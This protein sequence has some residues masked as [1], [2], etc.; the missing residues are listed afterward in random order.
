MAAWVGTAQAL[1]AMK[2]KWRG[3]LM[4]I[5]QP[6]EE[7][8]TGARAMLAD[9]LFERFPKPDVGF[10]LHVG[11]GPAG[12]V[13]YRPG[14]NSSNSDSLDITFHGK[15]GHGSTPHVTIDPVSRPPASPWM[16]RP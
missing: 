13:S 15:G 11:P 12:M 8:V 6:S 14:V 4:F 10:A 1:I 7:T 9:G 5:G 16:C 2:A 3:T